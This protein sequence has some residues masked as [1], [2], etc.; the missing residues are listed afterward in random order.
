[1]TS[2]LWK[3]GT[4]RGTSLVPREVTVLVPR[5]VPK[6]IKQPIYLTLRGSPL[7]LWK[8]GNAAKRARREAGRSLREMELRHSDSNETACG[9]EN[10]S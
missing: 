10:R 4:P 2:S 3:S 9:T 7:A 8:T 1:M 5:R 6:P